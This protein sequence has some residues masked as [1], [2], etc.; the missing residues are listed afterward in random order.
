MVYCVHKN[1]TLHTLTYCVCVCVC[2]C[3]LC[4]CC[5]FTCRYHVFKQQMKCDMWQVTCQDLETSFR[6]V[7]F[8]NE[9][10][11]SGRD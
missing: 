3:V 7:R 11:G 5:V 8:K 6:F 4:V 9:A 1:L 10:V 2:V